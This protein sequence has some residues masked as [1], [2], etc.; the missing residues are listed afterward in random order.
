M[1]ADQLSTPDDALGRLQSKLGENWV[2]LAAARAEA[3][4]NAVQLQTLVVSLK[5]PANT[6]V[7]GFGSLAREEW[8]PGSDVDWT[9]LI[10]GPADMEHFGVAAAV[11]R[12]LKDNG[13]AEPGSTGIFGTMSTSHQ[14]VHEIGGLEDTNKNITRRILLILE[15]VSLSDPITHERVIREILKRYIVGDPPTTDP[16]RFRV[17]L[18]LFNDIVRYWRTLCVDYATKK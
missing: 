6:S 11:E 1:P 14:L 9:L 12:A 15:S 5:P 2:H 8:T 4:A 3:R 7:V 13:F 16:T 17:P 10:D 18:F